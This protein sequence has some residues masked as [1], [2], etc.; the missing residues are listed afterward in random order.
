ME[1]DLVTCGSWWDR[2]AYVVSIQP[3]PHSLWWM[4]LFK[5]LLRNLTKVVN[6]PDGGRLLQRVIYVVDIHLPLIK[7]VME[8]IHSLYGSGA[9]L[10][11]A[12]DQVD[13][14]VQVGTHVITLQ[15]L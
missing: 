13:P 5:Q 4:R 8:D 11:I 15:S 1:K 10:L 7:K 14:L 2:D 6:E 12:K 3:T 9:L